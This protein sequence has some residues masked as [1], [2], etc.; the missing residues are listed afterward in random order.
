MRSIRT[1]LIVSFV[2]LAVVV[3]GTIA[4]YVYTITEHTLYQQDRA[5]EELLQA[6][7]EARC[8]AIRDRFDEELLRRAAKV[9]SRSQVVT[10]P[11]VYSSWVLSTALLGRL[12]LSGA[13]PASLVMTL[14]GVPA[15]GYLLRNAPL[16]LR[17][18]EEVLPREADAE[19]S[20]ESEYCLLYNQHLSPVQFSTT[21]GPKRMPALNRTACNALATYES[22]FEEFELEGQRLR[23][24]VYKAVVAGSSFPRRPFPFP[25][26]GGG[27]GGGNRSGRSGTASNPTAREPSRDPAS[28][29]QAPQNLPP[30]V[31]NYP[32][33][34]VQYVRGTNGRDF[35]LARCAAE[36]K[37]DTERVHERTRDVL[38]D[39][40]LR[41]ALVLVAAA[42]LFAAGGAFLGARGLK[43]L[44]QLTEAVSR[45]SEK[46]FDLKIHPAEVPQELAPIVTKLQQS[47]ASLEKA[48]R[49]EK[50]AVADI[51]HELRTPI[52]SLVTT[53]QVCL[54]KSRTSE[55]YQ[56]AMQNCAEIGNHLHD[57]VQRLLTLARIDA[58]VDMPQKE[59]FEL[60]DVGKSC[61]DMVRP[62][63]E[64]KGL[65]ALGRLQPGVLVDSDAA[66]VREIITNLLAN[67]VQYNRPQGQIELNIA[68][69]GGQALIEV[70]DN[71][72]GI[73]P[74]V[75]KHLFERF[76]RADPSRHAREP[77]AGLGL[78]IVKG[79]LDLL[80]GT[81]AVES[82]PGGGSVFQVRLPLAPEPAADE[83][84]EEAAPLV[85][86]AS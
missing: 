32:T 19:H 29:A 14:P 69:Q 81:I 18:A 84:V 74:E 11:Q 50:Q 60:A 46:D 67:A 10:S 82:E 40:R 35:E 68:A 28:T 12:D 25:R 8:H 66:K 54:K 41:L 59:I 5:T 61:L 49:H 86:A 4:W 76:Y 45:V 62:L 9:A 21:L 51:S 70:K 31:M 63:A 43:P 75:R 53:I 57:L 58:G 72:I 6:Q 85:R 15:G 30:I 47:L 20:H 36:L 73:G 83:T 22:L 3:L 1:T 13:P 2:S 48:F 38:A 71:G 52:A 7:Y 17:V 78:A 34:Y 24:V 39:L 55:E 79:Y 65:R 64:A 44:D 23:R 33:L 37:L 80:G 56:A 77:H 16:Q 42:V 26:G 27:G